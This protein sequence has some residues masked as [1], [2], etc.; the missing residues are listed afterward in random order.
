MEQNIQR[1]GTFI[2]FLYLSVDKSYNKNTNIEEINK[3]DKKKCILYFEIKENI[4]NQQFNYFKILDYG[5]SYDNFPWS[6]YLFFNNDLI[7]NGINTKQKAWFQSLD[8]E[9]DFYFIIEY[10]VAPNSITVT[11]N[12]I[13]NAVALK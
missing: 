9:K 6:Q 5:V 2:Y 3:Y 1:Y 4:I 8:P 11:I 13:G 10:N 7:Q 12:N